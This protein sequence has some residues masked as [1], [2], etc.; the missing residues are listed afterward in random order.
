MLTELLLYLKHN[1]KFLWDIIDQLNSL[2]FRFLHYYQIRK[3]VPK[4]LQEYSLKGYVFREL[5]QNDLLLLKDLIERQERGRLTYFNPHGFELKDL[6]KVYNNPSFI[7]MGVFDGR[8]MVGY[9][10]LRCFWNRKCFV[11]RL[12]DEPH[13]GRGIGRVMNSIMYNTAWRMGFRC[14]STISKNNTSVIRAHYGNPNMIIL[15][16]LNNSYMLVEFVREPK[17]SKLNISFES[18]SKEEG[19]GRRIEEQD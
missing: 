17:D 11:G 18:L 10:F 13:E 3:I 1:L 2:L 5:I 14:L 16:E 4:V 12:I 6:L 7:M 8:L 15:K 19:S 9:F